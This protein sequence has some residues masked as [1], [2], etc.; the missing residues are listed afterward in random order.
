M[1]GIPIDF[2]DLDNIEI[3]EDCAQAIG[4]MIND[5][6]VGLQGKV[7]AKK[8]MTSG[9][10]GGMLVSKD[11]A[12]VDA[13]RDYREFDQRRDDKKRFNFQMTDLQAAVAREQLLKLPNFIER[14]SVIFDRYKQSGIDLLDIDLQINKHRYPIRYRAVMKTKYPQKIIESLAKVRVKAIV[15]IEDWELLGEP[16]LV[17]RALQLTKETVSLPI[18]PS[19]SDENIKKIISAVT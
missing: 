4:A 13:V 11:K 6:K 5:D 15:P 14:R 3:I 19:L 7:Y 16:A 2:S 9:G 18:Y 12:L 17:P 10:H 1:F 8:L